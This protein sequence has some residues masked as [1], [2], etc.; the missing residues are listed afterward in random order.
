MGRIHTVA[1]P[2]TT[3]GSAGSATG[4]GVSDALNGYIIDVYFD[5]HASTPATTDTTLAYTLRGGNIV[6][7]TDSATDVLVAPRQKYVDNANSAITNSNGRFAVDGTL[8]VSLAQSD[9]LTNAV[10]AYVRIEDSLP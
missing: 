7:V 6:V 9:A 3:T 5:F 1:I 8:T 10:I 4:S 2:V